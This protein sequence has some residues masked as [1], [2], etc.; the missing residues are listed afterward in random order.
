RPWCMPHPRGGKYGEVFGTFGSEIRKLGVGYVA[1]SQDF[2]LTGTFGGSARL[3]D[4][5]LAGGNFAA[6]RLTEKSRIGMLPPSCP[7]LST[8]PKHGYG[9]SPFAER[10]AALWRAPALVYEPGKN[11]P[12]TDAGQQWPEEWM[13]QYAPEHLPE[14]AAAFPLS[15]D[16]G[17]G[18]AAAGTTGGSI[19]SG[20]GAG[21]VRFPGM[22][23]SGDSAENAPAEPDAA[24]LSEADQRALAI[25]QGAPQ[26]RST[27]AAALGITP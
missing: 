7:S 13:Q 22:G 25:I 10:P 8:V 21:V 5:F 12:D 19:H 14:L 9:F 6:M 23:S 15:I 20:N 1:A 27:L 3:R 16:S 2:D 24:A 18:G 4:A 26:T 11:E 17:S